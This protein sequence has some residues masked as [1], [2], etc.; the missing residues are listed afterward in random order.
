MIAA[1]AEH[2]IGFDDLSAKRT[3]LASIS[4]P[5]TSTGQGSRNCSLVI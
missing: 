2:G 3:I 1:T 4:T 5:T